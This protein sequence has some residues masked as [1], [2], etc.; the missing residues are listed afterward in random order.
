MQ[1]LHDVTD[2]EGQEA[3]FASGV[4]TLFDA[5]TP[6]KALQTRNLRNGML[7]FHPGQALEMDDKQNFGPSHSYSEFGD[8]GPDLEVMFHG[9][10]DASLFTSSSSSPLHH[11]YNKNS[12]SSSSEP[13]HHEL[14]N[15]RASIRKHRAHLDLMHSPGNASLDMAYQSSW[16]NRFQAFN[17]QAHDYQI[18]L[19]PTSPPKPEPSENI[20]RL[21]EGESSLQ[22]NHHDA[23]S[24]YSQ[25]PMVNHSRH[26]PISGPCT[27]QGMRHIYVDQQRPATSASP[28]SPP[29]HHIIRSQHSEPSSMSSW[30]SESIDA[31]SFHYST[32]LQ[33]PDGQTWWQAPEATN[34]D[35]HSYSQSPYQ[36]MVV[37]PTAQKPPTHQTRVLQGTSMMHM[38]Q[39]TDIGSAKP[40][41]RP[42]DKHQHQ[43]KSHIRKPSSIS[44]HSQRSIKGTPITPNS[45]TNPIIRRPLSVSFVN[46]TPED[47]QKLLT[48][49]AP[50]GSS[51]TKARREQEAREKRRKLS[52]A[53]LLAVK[54]AGGDVEA[55][56]A[57]FC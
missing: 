18:A 16:A 44:T 56:E 6:C 54:R 17:I 51:K 37:A 1:T 42:H 8:P 13:R 12:P 3:A 40:E 57:V 22:N 36:P 29:S 7:S 2:K 33:T 25:S 50:S 30:N 28:I 11:I 14:N 48:G 24:T 32:D 45:N 41:I 46:F 10:K 27:D 20:A 31:P 49:V 19:P 26:T 35:L 39:S 15:P 53:A 34:R 43:R 47:S 5:G 9:N 38:G 23:E 52:E 21:T 55:F 4:N